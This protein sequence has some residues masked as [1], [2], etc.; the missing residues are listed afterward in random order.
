MILD[1]PFDCVVLQLVRSGVKSSHNLVVG[2]LGVFLPTLPCQ[3]LRL[4][5]I[6]PW[7]SVEKDAAGPSEWEEV[8]PLEGEDDRLSNRPLGVVEPYHVVPLHVG[9]FAHDELVEGR[10]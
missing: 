5:I 7:W 3:D 8:R 2:K 10:L 1:F 9:L 4:F 6:A